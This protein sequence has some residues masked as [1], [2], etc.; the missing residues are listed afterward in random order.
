MDAV[1]AGKVTSGEA[2]SLAA[3]ALFEMSPDSSPGTAIDLTRTAASHG[4]L[5]RS[6]VA[7]TN[8]GSAHTQKGSPA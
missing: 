2:A 4:E 6:A 1:P 7:D 3:H 5:R 8:P